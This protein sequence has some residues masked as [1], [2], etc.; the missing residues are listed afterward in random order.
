MMR[1]FRHVVTLAAILVC[2]VAVADMANT[3]KTVRV[4]CM[5]PKAADLGDGGG[6]PVDCGTGFT[7]F[8]LENNN[9]TAHVYFG[10]PYYPDAGVSPRD[11]NTGTYTLAGDKRGPTARAGNTWAG[12]VSQRARYS[13]VGEPGAGQDASVPLAVHCWR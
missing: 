12:N 2:G 11:F 6:T 8:S 1:R 5:I 13:C 4:N 3:V 9:A 10:V 7:G